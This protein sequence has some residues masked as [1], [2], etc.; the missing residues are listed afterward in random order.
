MNLFKETEEMLIENGKTWDD[1]VFISTTNDSETIEINVDTFVEVSKNINYD[2]GFGGNEINLNLVIAGEYW[3]LERREYD[4]AENWDY[5][6][7]PRR[8]K[9]KLNEAKALLLNRDLGILS[10]W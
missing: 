8:P 10:G 2:N 9:T 4:G 7:K 3:W 5:K 1:V 6:E